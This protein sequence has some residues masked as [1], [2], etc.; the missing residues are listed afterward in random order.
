MGK[1]LSTCRRKFLYFSPVILIVFLC[2]ACTNLGMQAGQEEASG[3]SV[4]VRTGGPSG[5]YINDIA[6]CAGNPD[7]LYAAGSRKGIYKSMDGGAQ[8]ELLP[9]PD[10]GAAQLVEADP[11][12][13]KVIYADYH[14]FSR[15][16]DGGKTWSEKTSGMSGRIVSLDFLLAP[17]NPKTLYL[18]GFKANDEIPVVYKSGNSGDSWQNIKGNLPAPKG[19][20][21]LCLALSGKRIFIAVNDHSLENWHRGKVFSSDDEGNTWREVDYGSKHDRFILSIFANPF[22]KKE[23]W[24]SEG[25]LY[26]EGLAQPLLYKSTDN[27]ETWTPVTINCAFDSTQSRVIGAG[28]DNR[29]YA[30]CGSNL[31]YTDNGGKSFNNLLQATVDIIGVDFRHLA[32]HPEKPATLFL[33]LRAAGIACSN[34]GGQHWQLINKGIVE[35][36]IN[37]LATDPV[38]PATLYAASAAGEGLFRSDDSGD[39]WVRLNSG[40]IVHPWADEIIVEPSNASHVWYVGD[41]PYIQKSTNRGASWESIVDPRESGAFNF[42]SVYAMAQGSNPDLFYALS[43]GFGIYRGIRE[44]DHH[45]RW[46]FLNLSEIDYTYT[47]AVHPENSN[48]LYSGYIP[49]PFQD[50]AMIRRTTDAGQNW[51]TILNVPGSKGITTIAVDPENPNILYAGSIG[52]QG[53]I[54]KS[55][56]RGNTWAEYNEA[57]NMCTVWGQAQLMADP[58]NPSVVYA[59]TWLAGTWKSENAGKTWQLLKGAPIS[60]TAIS[61]NPENTDEIYLADRSSPTVWKSADGGLTWNRIADFSKDGALLVM[62]VFA[63]GETIYA[64]TFYPRLMGG[65]LYKSADSGRTWEDITGTLPRGI[66]D[67]AVDPTNKDIAYATTNISGVYKTTD[68]GKSW[69]ELKA[70]PYVGVYDLEIDPADPAVLYASARGG[71]LPAWFTRIAGV[72]GGIIFKDSAGVYKSTDAGKSWKKILTTSASCRAVRIHP[73]NHNLLFAVDLVDGLF[74]SQNRGE[75]WSKHKTGDRKLALTSCTLAGNKVYV[76]TQGCGIYSGD[77]DLYSEKASISLNWIEERSNKPVPEVHSL[78]IL[79]D[80]TDSNSIFVSSFPGG[81]YRSDKDGTFRDRNGITPS[82][83]VEDPFRQGYYTIAVNPAK[84]EEMWTGTWGR[85]IYKSLDACL[86][87][88]PMNGRDRIMNGKHITQI[89]VSP[90][91]RNTV[92]V[93]SEEGVFITKNGGETWR[94]LNRGLPSLDIRSIL[95]NS[96]GELFAGTK[97]YGIFRWDGDTWNALNA[98]GNFGIIWPLWDDRPMYQYTSVLIHPKNPDLVMIGTFPQGI[99]LSRDGGMNWKESNLGWTLDGVFR[100]VSHPDNPDIVYAGTYNAVS[101]SYDF[102]GHWQMLDKGWPGEQWVF[103]IDFNHDD[104]SV[105]YACSKNGANEGTG[106]DDFHGIVMKSEDGGMHWKE[107]MNGLSKDQEFYE[108]IVDKYDQNILYLA[109]QREGVMISRDG[110]RS[111]SSWNEGMVNPVPATNGNNVTRCLALSADGSTLY[112]G[113]F[114]SGVFRRRIAK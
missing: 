98:F 13:S 18:C 57:F 16:M 55:I 105:M 47:L 46:S 7:I 22:N 21:A 19:S 43:N 35:T 108:I 73:V 53:Q 69:Q 26:N 39:T 63:A 11:D 77:L 67:I 76:G 45:W 4:W 72:E 32:V 58:E 23:L 82:V 14:T 38:N 6:I 79:I 74:I 61:V 27:G 52:K 28:P 87:N 33:P 44:N 80:P 50:W 42:C 94:P 100:L 31:I 25:P 68:A 109:A 95:L 24:I 107:I 103:S 101:I 37:L 30:G 81:V 49:K 102:G 17:Q 88:V 5:G 2:A 65:K 29:I 66:L 84:P 70:F 92:Y 20:R 41:V 89:C 112:F 111:W 15:S 90:L 75:T 8:W 64:S 51:D 83:I 12:N 48:I 93:A 97:G 10:R 1:T 106:E 113:S 78:Q 91:E 99:Y 71:S 40:G 60:G 96:N 9:F 114:K 3:P 104:P 110:G 54:F 36:S 59:T 56:D 86:L 85:G 34:D 62:R